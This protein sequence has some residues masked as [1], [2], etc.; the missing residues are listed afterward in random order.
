MRMAAPIIVVVVVLASMLTACGASGLKPAPPTQ[1]PIPVPTTQTPT[2][3]ATPVLSLQ[4]VSARVCKSEGFPLAAD[5][6]EAP[7]TRHKI[8]MMDEHGNKH[9]WFANL[10]ADLQATSI[11]ELEAVLCLTDQRPRRSISSCGKYASTFNPLSPIELYRGYYWMSARLIAA[12]TGKTMVSDTIESNLGSCPDEYSTDDPNLIEGAYFGGGITW[13]M[14][15]GLDNFGIQYTIIN[16]SSTP[17]PTATPTPTPLPP[18]IPGPPTDNWQVELDDDFTGDW[19]FSWQPAP[20]ETMENGLL[21]WHI[22]SPHYLYYSKV[23]EWSYPS[24]NAYVRLVVRHASGL[25]SDEYGL[26]FRREAPGNELAFLISDNG[27]FRLH[28][29]NGSDPIGQYPTNN[30]R[31][32]DWNTL[33]V[34]DYEGEVFLYINGVQVASVYVD[35]PYFGDVGI[36]VQVGEDGVTSYDSIF[37]FDHL[38]QRVPE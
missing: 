11:E 23:H 32:G 6:V 10:S 31:P 22:Q 26:L 19:I 7:G 35:E 5:Y 33:E 25:A 20:D 15:W 3:T 21:T 34:I 9:P 29:T 37:Q 17:T 38:E 16:P 27:T 12:K 8:Y 28:A 36:A 14:V 1:T 24:H 2:V 13:N 4:E 18:L 30:I